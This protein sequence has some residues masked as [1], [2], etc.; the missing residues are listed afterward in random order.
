MNRFTWVLALVGSGIFPAILSL[1]FLYWLVFLDSALPRK[2][3]LAVGIVLSLGMV[4]FFA[5]SAR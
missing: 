3:K 4:S 5:Y 1:V 2:T